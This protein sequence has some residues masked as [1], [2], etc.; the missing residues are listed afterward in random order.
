[1]QDNTPI[2]VKK[3]VDEA[4]STW[5][6]TASV[7]LRLP[8]I[9]DNS[10]PTAATD[11]GAIYFNREFLHGLA[12]P[13]RAFV[14]AHEIL[15]VVSLHMQR[16]GFRDAQKWNIA[17]DIVLHNTMPER[18]EMPAISGILYE[19]KYTGWCVEDVFDDLDMPDSDTSGGGSIGEILDRFKSQA[20][21]AL[22]KE[23]QGSPELR[24]ALSD[25]A[26]NSCGMDTVAALRKMLNDKARAESKPAWAQQVANDLRRSIGS[27]LPDRRYLAR[28]DAEGGPLWLE[29]YDPQAKIL[30][31]IDTSGSV[32]DQMLAQFGAV[33]LQVIEETQCE[34]TIIMADDRIHSVTDIQGGDPLPQAVGRGGTDF[35][36]AL[37]WLAEQPHGTYTRGYYYTDAQGTF[38]A[39]PPACP[40]TW[41]IWANSNSRPPEGWGDVIQMR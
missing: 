32:N 5:P 13:D 21:G 30:F 31:V 24:K 3:A 6:E 10:I 25:L 11:G 40:F 39:V 20:A 29:N 16:R 17:A 22:A 4:V 26:S 23:L 9:E 38:G 27:T 12:E 28:E 36:P 35:A 2:W 15:H 18:M 1:M 19:P 7:A 33:C 14:M 34:A 8:V 37:A 41:V